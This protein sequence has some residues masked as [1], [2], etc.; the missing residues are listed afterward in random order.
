MLHDILIAFGNFFDIFEMSRGGITVGLC[1]F[2][3]PPP[4]SQL[5]QKDKALR[6]VSLSMEQGMQQC[7]H[8]TKRKT[9]KK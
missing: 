6:I 4:A 9:K 1:G 7:A 2:S 3:P 5:I 8:C